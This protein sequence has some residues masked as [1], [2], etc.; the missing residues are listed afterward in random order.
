MTDKKDILFKQYKLY[1][2]TA[3]R[4]SDRRQNANS[5]FLTLNSILV[6]FTGF[7]TTLPFEIWHVLIAIAGLS[8]SILWLLTLR[9]FRKLNESKF[10]IIHQLEEKMPSKLFKDEWDYL[11]K[12]ENKTKYLK[13]SVIEQGI[14]IIFSILYISII[15]LMVWK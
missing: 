11:H 15:I 5:F 13:L 10:K 7:L 14:P 8:I 12:E 2:E 9:S 1:V 4:V 6:A 3:E